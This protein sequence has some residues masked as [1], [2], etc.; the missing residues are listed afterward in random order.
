LF[1]LA[2]GSLA[3][4][5][6]LVR[7][8]LGPGRGYAPR[9][10]LLAMPVVCCLYFIRELYGPRRGGRLV[11]IGLLLLLAL[12]W[13]LNVRATLACGREHGRKM[14]VVERAIEAGEQ[15]HVIAERH[16]KF[17][18]DQMPSEELTEYLCLLHKARV[19][20]FGRLPEDVD[21][22]EE[23][24]VAVKPSAVH[25]LTWGDGTGRAEGADSYLE[26]DLPKVSWV[27][28]IRIKCAYEETAGPPSLRICWR[29]R[30][31]NDYVDG[32]RQVRLDLEKG[33]GEQTRTVPVEN[34]ID[35]LR[36]Y[37]GTKPC[38]LK[39]SEITLRLQT[40]TESVNAYKR[41]IGQIQGVVGQTL[42]P[43]TTVLVVSHGDDHLLELGGRRGWHFP[44]FETGEWNGEKPTDSGQA[45]A[46][47]NAL[48]TKGAGF[49]LVPSTECWWLEYYTEFQ[50]YLKRHYRAVHRGDHCIIFDLR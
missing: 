37:L 13:P 44:Q 36:I 17:L 12:L 20:R 3:F 27:S 49:L 6:G 45:I 47:L 16:G 2:V 28:A 43:N 38:V 33:P 31:E 26:F 29:R 35:Q 23:D 19:G 25:R 5:V 40:R 8:G 22:A 50:T 1:L 34:A 30:A 21:L 42:P 9:Y 41:M 18:Y 11:P 10:V 32:R 4:G 48:R 14:A 24:R 46:Q 15:P 39:I 7:S